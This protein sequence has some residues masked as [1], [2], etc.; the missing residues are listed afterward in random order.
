MAAGR[1]SDLDPPTSTITTV[2]PDADLSS[3]A[4]S[5]R[6]EDF[7]EYL[8]ESGFTVTVRAGKLRISPRASMEPQ[9]ALSAAEQAQ[10]GRHAREL[11]RLA[12]RRQLQAEAMD[13]FLASDLA[14]EWPFGGDGDAGRETV[15][16]GFAEGTADE[17]WVM[18]FADRWDALVAEC[19][20]IRGAQ[21][22]AAA[23]EAERQA[24][25]EAEREREQENR[26]RAAAEAQAGL[27]KGKRGKRAGPVQT[28]ALFKAS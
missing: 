21:E 27:P 6:A 13:R 11:G 23:K 8:W 9:P 1:R 10:V 15:L 14:R 3:K 16:V 7:W 19:A 26:R 5:T 28:S 4:T 22:E 17:F 20:T 24:R 18:D 12:R 25:L 2:K